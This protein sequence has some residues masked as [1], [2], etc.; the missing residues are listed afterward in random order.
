MKI[1]VIDD[2]I[3]DLQYFLNE[4]FKIKN[5][6]YKFFDDNREDRLCLVLQP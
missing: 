1:I 6:E 2:E 3:K 5:I 4:V